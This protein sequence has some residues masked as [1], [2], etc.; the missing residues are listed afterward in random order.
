MRPKHEHTVPPLSRGVPPF[1]ATS[2][3]V[4]RV[5]SRISPAKI[6]CYAER[7]RFEWVANRISRPLPSTTR[8]PI[9]ANT[10]IN[11]RLPRRNAHP[12]RLLA[13][14]HPADFAVTSR[15]EITGSGQAATP[16]H[17]GK[18]AGI[19]RRRYKPSCVRRQA[20]PASG[21]D[22]SRRALS[23]ACNDPRCCITGTIDVTLSASIAHGVLSSGNNGHRRRC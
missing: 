11:S 9:P 10:L 19:N 2:R 16:G 22:G 17:R 6:R 12:A 8:P 18:P 23:H 20:W 13:E 7:S 1:C 14:A 15:R 4:F 21:I 5:C 3:R